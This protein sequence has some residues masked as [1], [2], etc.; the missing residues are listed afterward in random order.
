MDTFFGAALVCNCLAMGSALVLLFFRYL[1]RSD[2][3]RAAPAGAFGC[4]LA[5]VAVTAV[6]GLRPWL[7]GIATVEAGMVFLL[8]RRS[9]MHLPGSLLLVSFYS[10]VLAAVTWYIHFAFTINVSALTRAFFIA[11]I[12]SM[13]V[14][15]PMSCVHSFLDIEAFCREKWARRNMPHASSVVNGPKVSVHLPC[16]AEP[17]DMVIA[18]LDALARLRYDN[19]EVVVVD[20]NT[21]DPALW[22]PVE[23]HCRRLGER[24]RFFHVAPLAGAKGGALNFAL[25][26]TAQDAELIALVDADYQMAPDFL[27]R[28]VGHFD[29]KRLGFIQAKYNFRDWQDSLFRSGAYWGYQVSFS[30]L[31]RSRNDRMAAYPMGTSCVLRRAAIVDAGGWSM[32]CVTEDSEIGVRIQAVGYRSFTFDD[33][34]GAGLVPETFAAFKKQRFRWT[35]GPVQQLKQHWRLFL[36][37]RFATPSTMSVQQKIL[38]LEHGFV[39]VT[40]GLGFLTAMP[41]ALAALVSML[42]HG[43]QPPMNRGLWI[44]LVMGLSSALAL[45]WCRYR[46]IA[47]SASKDTLM[48]MVVDSSLSWI[49]TCATLHGILTKNTAWRRTTKFKAGA[50]G[51]RVLASVRVELALALILTAA[52]IGAIASD[53][54]G[55][56]LLIGAIFGLKSVVYYAAVCVAFVA[57][58]DLRRA[59]AVAST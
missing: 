23:E 58:R 36:P 43:E 49:C 3:G 52:A 22:R 18:S 13:L 21:R 32:S 12:P 55:F 44:G 6:Y 24:F 39:L 19:F 20:N 45:R 47:G 29:D 46:Y 41:L 57:E 37:R 7:V 51:W 30:M 56:L 15:L 34:V 53:S 26:R 17:P 48:A 33:P 35:Y 28:L 2:P 54:S 16:Y 9:P 1:P 40:G 11:G 38:G 42:V 14:A 31:F 5:V 50:S 59:A 4:L 8:Y 10:A 27:A 25:A